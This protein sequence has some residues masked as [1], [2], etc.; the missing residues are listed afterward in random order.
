MLHFSISFQLLLLY[1]LF[2]P[3]VFFAVILTKN[4]YMNINFFN[5][6]PLLIG[7]TAM[8]NIISKYNTSRYKILVLFGKNNSSGPVLNRV[9]AALMSKIFY[10][11]DYLNTQKGSLL[12]PLKISTTISAYHLHY[13]ILPI[14]QE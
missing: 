10:V 13:S 9:M 3:R 12:I 4:K 5:R 2:F 11:F 14:Q 8:G 7:N 6:R 1:Y